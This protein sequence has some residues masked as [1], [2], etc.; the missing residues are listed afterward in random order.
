MSVNSQN[1]RFDKGK[2]IISLD[3]ELMWGVHDVT[4]ASVYGD[5]IIGAKQI[6]PRIIDKFE[7]NCI[8]ATWATVGFLF[9]RNERD[10]TAGSLPQLKPGYHDRGLSPYLSDG[11]LICSGQDSSCYFFA[12]DLLQVLIGSRYQEVATHTFSH[13][14]CLE[15]G[16]TAESFEADLISAI[17]A[18]KKEGLTLRSIV[19]PRNQYNNEA[20]AICQKHGIMCFR[21]NEESWL[22]APTSS[23][24]QSLTRRAIRLVDKY[25]N[26]TGYNC[27]A[28]KDLREKKKESLVNLPSSLF[29]RPYNPRLAL[30]ERMK[31]RRVMNAMT[32]AAKEGLLFHLWWHPHNFGR[33]QHDNLKQL[34]DII[35]HYCFLRNE[36]GFES[37]S[38]SEL[39]NTI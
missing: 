14:Y 33:N 7:V 27:Y 17:R 18:A 24:E 38:M 9:F 8:S 12:Y 2:L 13:Y 4:S 35:S 11:R 37:V 19:F 23:R 16:A 21:G 34:D 32:H 39:G 3:F 29:L 36:Y 30:F 25:I 15:E 6:I 22:Y 1:D 20:L 31:L 10:I 28:L 26:V 5:A